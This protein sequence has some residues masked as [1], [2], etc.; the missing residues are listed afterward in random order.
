MARGNL[1]PSGCQWV[2][3]NG[4]CNGLTDE[5][6]CRLVVQVSTR[7]GWRERT[8][9]SQVRDQ[10]WQV[11]AKACSPRVVVH[12]EAFPSPFGSPQGASRRAG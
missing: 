8:C 5:N 9:V 3:D 10:R 6:G 4:L 11:S 12:A 1:R 2:L 7:E